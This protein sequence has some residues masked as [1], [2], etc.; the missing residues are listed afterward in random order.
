MAEA[1]TNARF[2]EEWEAVS[3]GTRPAG[4][5]HPLASAVLSEIGIEHH[6]PAKSVYEYRGSKFDVIVTV[7]DL[8]R[9]ECPRWISADSV[10]HDSFPDPLTVR[11][12]GGESLRTFRAVRDSIAGTLSVL[13]M[14]ESHRIRLGVAW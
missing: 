1:I 7:G 6:G 14:M 2:G 13:L 5:V 3:A 9:E 10:I 11:E 4:Y 8:A 12:S